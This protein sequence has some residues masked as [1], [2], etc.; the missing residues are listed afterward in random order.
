MDFKKMTDSE[1]AK[2]MVNY[3]GRVEHLQNIIS[4]YLQ[5]KRS[6]GNGR[7][8]TY[9]RKNLRAAFGDSHYGKSLGSHSVIFALIG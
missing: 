2:V 3:I 1:L 5:G 6:C 9:F 8:G 7:S 4:R